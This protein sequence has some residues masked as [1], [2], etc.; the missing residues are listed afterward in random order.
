[1][2]ICVS[3]TLIRVFTP[4]KYTK[5]VHTCISH[6]NTLQRT[7]THCNTLRHIATH[8]NTLQ[9]ISGGFGRFF[10]F[11]L[12]PRFSPESLVVFVCFV[13]LLGINF[14]LSWVLFCFVYYGC[15]TVEQKHANGTQGF[16]ADAKVPSLV[17]GA[18]APA[19]LLS[20][21]ACWVCAF[22]ASR[23]LALARR[24]RIMLMCL[25]HLPEWRCCVSGTGLWTGWQTVAG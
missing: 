13:C 4:I 20:L 1:M 3:Y 9:S 15:H 23:A 18:W 22:S 10:W 11:P 19:P 17:P 14:F 7:A 24:P 8:C 25:G 6:C 5:N 16:R 2:Q 12:N 21:S